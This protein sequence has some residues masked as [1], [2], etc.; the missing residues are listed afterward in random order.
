MKNFVKLIFFIFII[1]QSNYTIAQAVKF[2]KVY[3]GT[4]YDYGHSVA[5]T[6]DKGYVIA[7]ATT[8]FGV[9]STDAYIL[10]TDS[11]GVVLWQKTF[12]G[13]N[14]D[15][16]YSI[17]ETS[18]SGFVMAGFTNSEGNG[19]YD[20]YVVKTDKNGDSLWTKSFGGTNWDFAYSV[21][22]TSDG[23]YII[24]G[25]TYSYGNGNTDMYL[26]KT[27]ADGDTLWTKSFGGANVDEARSVKQLNDGGFVL[28]GSSKSYDADG[29]FY[30]IRTNSLGDTLW[31]NKFGGAE[32]DAAF[33]ILESITGELII[34]G[35][36]KSLGNGNFDGLIIKLSPSGLLTS[37]VNYGGTDDDGL[38]A[39]A[40]S[41]TG[42]LAMVG[43]TYSFSSGIG[44]SD[45]LLYI[46]NP[47][48][49][50]HSGT[51]GG[52]KLEKAYSISNTK[53]NGYIICGN[54]SSYSNLE[55]IYLI[56]T[57]SNGVS[58]GSVINFVTDINNNTLKSN[59]NF[60]IFPNPAADNL[61]L[62]FDFLSPH[63]NLSYQV[64]ITD[65][66]GRLKLQEL[67]CSSAA[68]PFFMDV[69]GLLSGVYFI[70]I[71]NNF[72][73]YNQK[74]IIQH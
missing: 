57:D 68:G 3:G 38:N 67:N 5:Q 29:D 15:Q 1:C 23:G 7:G 62:N 60:N 46:E 9:G 51:F 42:R 2:E 27:D 39:I 48:N 30:T 11:M 25:A 33:D 10:K 59:G 16:F 54:T 17:K 40:E 19:G 58:S 34:G 56:K 6:F 74:I 4:G 49:G 41:S 21:E 44:T 47:F 63:G 69:S 70:N 73:S 20:M 71:E 66:L 13:I 14:I 8:S 28:T 22:Q 24:A 64:T 55:H 61:F 35:K 50:F 32:E 31:T 37:V 26:V 53:D 36:T 12:G 65:V 52:F 45:Y 18:D 72:F 43:Y